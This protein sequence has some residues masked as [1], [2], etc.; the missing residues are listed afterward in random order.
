MQTYD[1]NFYRK[2]TDACRQS[3]RVMVPLVLDLLTPRRVVDVGCGVGTWLAVFREHG[4]TDL[5]GIDGEYVDRSMLEIPQAQFLAADLTIGERE[6]CEVEPRSVILS[7]PLLA[8][9][10][11]G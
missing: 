9:E 2:E 5:L 11:P 1:Q 6:V 8:L 4:L 10:H 7:N 3:A